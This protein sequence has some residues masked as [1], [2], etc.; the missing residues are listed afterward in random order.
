MIEVYPSIGSGEHQVYLNSVNIVF[1]FPGLGLADHSGRSWNTAI[2]ALPAH[3][4]QFDLGH[5]ASTST[6]S[7]EPTTWFLPAQRL[8]R[9]KRVSGC[10]GCL[11]PPRSSRLL[12]TRHLRAHACLRRG[13]C[14]CDG[15]SPGH[16]VA[17]AGA[18]RI[19]TGRRPLGTCT[20]SRIAPTDQDGQE[21]VGKVGHQLRAGFSCILWGASGHKGE[22]KHPGYLR[23]ADKGGVGLGCDT[24]LLFQ[25]RFELGFLS[26]VRMVSWETASRYCN[27]TIFPARRRSV[28]RS[29]P[30]GV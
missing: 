21:G 3:H 28:Q 10:S 23:V 13:P 11:T 16:A 1:V 8:R 24:P 15:G 20:R 27:P 9:T 7:V 6:F 5:A 22:R 26:A 2:Q 25:P 14:G 12:D 29:R 30:S 18:R 4:A 19:E 17:L